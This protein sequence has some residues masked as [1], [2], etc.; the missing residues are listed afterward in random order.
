MKEFYEELLFVY[1]DFL[2]LDG[3]NKNLYVIMK[4][5]QT[6]GHGVHLVNCQIFGVELKVYLSVSF[7]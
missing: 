3:S 4:T 2:C 1:C 6:C 5:V 7:S